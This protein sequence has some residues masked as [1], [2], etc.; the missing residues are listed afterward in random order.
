MNLSLSSQCYP[1]K[2]YFFIVCLLLVS[3][4]QI[5][6]HHL[7]SFGKVVIQK[8][9]Y[10]PIWHTFWI[11]KLQACIATTR[12]FDQWLTTRDSVTHPAYLHAGNMAHLEL[13]LIMHEDHI[14][15]HWCCLLYDCG[16]Q[17]QNDYHFVVYGHFDSKFLIWPGV[18]L[19]HFCDCTTR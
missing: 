15:T 7:P 18:N 3:P 4:R 14:Q 5:C 2:F 12:I 9:C 6:M 8:Y 16:L 13:Q 19:A 1:L 10:C 17:L 11:N